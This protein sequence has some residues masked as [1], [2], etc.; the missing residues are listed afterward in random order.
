MWTDAA[1][2]LTDQ[3]DRRC[4][5]GPDGALEEW[6]TVTRAD[7]VPM[8]V[9]YTCPA[10]R[11]RA[12]SFNVHVAAAQ[13]P[14]NLSSIADHLQRHQRAYESRGEALAFVSQLAVVS[15]AGCTWASV[16]SVSEGRVH[17]L[18]A[19]GE[20]AREAD[21]LQDRSGTGP[22]VDSVTKDGAVRTADLCSDSRW[23]QLG[24]TTAKGTLSVRM[25]GGSD[26][27]ASVLTLYADRTDPFDDTSE[28]VAVL[29]AIYGGT[30]VAAAAAGS[31]TCTCNEHCS[32]T[33]RSGLPSVSSWPN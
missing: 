33:G 23:P 13:W 28:A 19:T 27:A 9:P 22:V 25:A 2:A 15:A 16:A 32:P 30:V 12:G 8:V 6:P 26:D 29:T 21:A 4:G 1:V 3:P 11:G 24:R 18:A 10:R 31:T 20:P 17:T 7:T 5:P 14:S